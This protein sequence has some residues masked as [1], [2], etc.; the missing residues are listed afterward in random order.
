MIGRCTTAGTI[1]EYTVPAGIIAP[2][3]ITAGSDGALW[4]TDYNDAIGRVTTAGGL[5][6]HNVEPPGNQPIPQYIA[7]GPDGA[8]WFT[9]SGG[10]IGRIIPAILSANTHDF[11][12][13]GYSDIL[14]RNA[15]NTVAVWLMTGI[16]GT[17]ELFRREGCI[18]FDDYF[19]ALP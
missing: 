5:A 8:L 17:G 18:A 2:Y 16:I 4:F 9:E 10:K 3:E 19:G 7:A 11:N 1:T 12:G 13:D 6:V 14:W 15:G